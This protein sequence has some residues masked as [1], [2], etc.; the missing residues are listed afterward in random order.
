MY[1]YAGTI[2]V[3]YSLMSH[4]D[5]DSL[6]DKFMLDY[7]PCYTVWHFAESRK[8]KR[9]TALLVMIAPYYHPRQ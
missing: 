6:I 7:I 9:K 3:Q 5:I 4:S 2:I 1:I 8:I